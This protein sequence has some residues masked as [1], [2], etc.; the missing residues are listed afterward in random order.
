MALLSKEGKMKYFKNEDH[1]AFKHL[2]DE[3]K[4]SI[5]DAKAEGRAEFCL[6]VRIS[7]WKPASGMDLNLNA[8]YRALPAPMT[9][10][11]LKTELVNAYVTDDCSVTID[12]VI[13]TL[14]ERGLAE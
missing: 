14:F 1:K 8:T 2:T 11:E 5:I 6:N 9:K 13:N 10:K 7:K 12:S 3:Q 4:L